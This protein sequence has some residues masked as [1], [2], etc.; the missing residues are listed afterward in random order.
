MKENG[1]CKKFWF[2]ILLLFATLLLILA[3]TIG[4]IFGVN[5]EPVNDDTEKP[6]PKN[7]VYVHPMFKPIAKK[8]V[9]V[10]K[11]NVMAGNPVLRDVRMPF[12]F[13]TSM[14]FQNRFKNRLE[15]KEPTLLLKS[16][17]STEASTVIKNTTF[18]ISPKVKKTISTLGKFISAN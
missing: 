7:I 10:I 17:N 2:K 15:T 13:W 4:I 1:L 9:T 14:N 5:S 6:K 18:S 3:V 16:S 8:G 11:S 12:L